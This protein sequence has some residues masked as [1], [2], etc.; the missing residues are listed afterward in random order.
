MRYR[1]TLRRLFV[2]VALVGVALAI[3]AGSVRRFQY[4]AIITREL[5]ARG[6]R[7][8]WVGSCVNRVSLEYCRDADECV[9]LMAKLSQHESF[10]SCNL[11]GS[12]ITDAGLQCL[13]A[14]P[15][16]QHINL[17]GNRSRPGVA[18]A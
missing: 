11:A 15:Q 10:E 14:M 5:I 2:V 6:A 4:D 18:G 7:V 8:T 12:D 3:M 13:L 9:A 17:S 16:L 1:F